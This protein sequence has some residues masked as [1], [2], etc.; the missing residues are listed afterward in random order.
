MVHT[1]MAEAPTLQEYIEAPQW[2]R[3]LY[4]R[5]HEYPPESELPPPQEYVELKT[6]RVPL[7]VYFIQAHCGA[8]KIGVA[9]DI[10]KRLRVLQS[11]HP[12]ELTLLAVTQ[13]GV[14]MEGTYHWRFRAH[15]IRGEWFEPHADILAEIERLKTLRRG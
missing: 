15:R 12:H 8:I 6:R 7:L 2:R 14:G 5:Y 9:N 4:R 13:G 11:G 1:Y 3:E 10:K